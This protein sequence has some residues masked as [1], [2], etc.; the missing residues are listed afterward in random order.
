MLE[1]ML[2]QMA[3][4]WQHIIVDLDGYGYSAWLLVY[5]PA[6]HFVLSA[7]VGWLVYWL[8]SIMLLRGSSTTL[9]ELKS[10]PDFSIHHFSLLL[11]LS[12]SVFAHILQDYT[13][14][15]F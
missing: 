8:T 10:R 12:S 11:A 7:I 1:R 14:N 5:A 4:L 3:G 13:L 2:E 9:R 6:A 15:W